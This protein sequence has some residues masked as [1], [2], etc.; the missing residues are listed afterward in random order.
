[1]KLGDRE[2]MLRAIALAT[3]AVANGGGPFG[4]LV[5]KSGQM[6][7]EGKNEAE[8]LQD[9][10]A[11]AEMQAIRAATNKLGSRWLTGYTL[12]TS[13]EP[14]PMCLAACYWADIE[15]I[16]YAV[17]TART[18]ALGLGDATVYKEICKEK[19]TRSIQMLE[20]PIEHDDAPFHVPHPNRSGL[21]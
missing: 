14:C 5:A 11:H 3:E 15:R 7:A 20:M 19:T 18:S 16:V 8:V 13:A 2:L 21:K 12:V 17:S 10:T 4:A 9:P 6:L 1:M